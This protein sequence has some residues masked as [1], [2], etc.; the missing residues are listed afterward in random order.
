MRVDIKDLQAHAVKGSFL[1]TPEQGEQILKEYGKTREDQ[2]KKTA[3]MTW[4]SSS[5]EAILRLTGEGKPASILNFASAK[6]PGG[7]FINGAKAQEES[8]AASS[9][10]YRTQLAHEEYYVKNR[11]FRSMMYTD[12]AIFS[13]D[14]VF[15][16]DERFCL[17]D[18]SF[19][20][21]PAG[22]QYGAGSVKRGGYGS[23]R[24]SH[25]APYEAV[26]C[27]FCMAGL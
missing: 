8:L 22:G 6:N 25:E 11:A 12:H 19:C 1:L 16:R 7:G 13:P 2:N 26:S 9:C 23:G 27:H 14:V 17:L 4:N 10:L 24:G 20:P 18:D 21:D 3:F 15:F 5:V